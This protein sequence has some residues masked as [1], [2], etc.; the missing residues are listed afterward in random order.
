MAKKFSRGQKA[1]TETFKF[2]GVREFTNL[3][4]DIDKSVEEIRIAGYSI[5]EEVLSGSELEITRSKLDEVYGLQVNEIGGEDHLRQINDVDIVRLP[6]AYDDFFLKLATN[7]KVLAIV[8]RLLGDYYIISQQNGIINPPG[9]ENYQISWHR[10]L[11]YQHFL[12]TRPLAVSALLCIDNFSIETGGTHV[13]PGSHKS[14]AFPS[15]R[16]VEKNEHCVTAKAG[17]A[18][19]F[20][21][22]LYHRA[23]SNRST[24]KRRALNHL[25]TLPFL[26]QQISIPDALQGR[27]RD[28]GF[29]SKFLGYE[30]EPG[31]NVMQWRAAKIDRTRSS[32]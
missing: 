29:L 19:V 6:L 3:S 30:S 31:K 15:Q 10:D 9:L 23:G 24:F 25:Y 28:E 4:T 22:M 7:T 1:M 8:E 27:F 2:Y 18:L 5:V 16:F 14:E 32:N 13:L 26:K 12:S 17:S 11:S 20:D 21:S